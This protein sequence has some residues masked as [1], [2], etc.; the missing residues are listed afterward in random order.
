MNDAERPADIT[1]VPNI[2]IL[3][4]GHYVSRISDY[5]MYSVE[6]ENIDKV[7]AAY[8]PCELP[9]H[10]NGVFGASLTLQMLV[11]NQSWRYCRR[12]NIVQSPGNN[13]I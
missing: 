10:H 6:A 2:E 13:C 1:E 8:G 12:A 11:S 5:I 3:R 9:L 4:N 7:V